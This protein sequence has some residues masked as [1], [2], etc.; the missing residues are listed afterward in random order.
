MISD[1]WWERN[2]TWAPYPL[3]AL[4]IGLFFTGR[5]AVMAYVELFRLLSGGATT[6]MAIAGW[7]LY[8]VPFTLLW[9][10]IL[11]SGRAKNCLAFLLLLV[12]ITLSVYPGGTNYWL[13]EAVSGPGGNAFVVGMRNGLLGGVVTSFTVPFV[14]ASE[15]LRDHF[16]VRTLGW[17]LAAPIGTFL[18]ATL[19]AAITLAAS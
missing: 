8:I 16:G 7:M 18:I 3:T 13:G 9:T 2:R 17:M 19:A 14:L 12:P 15:R 5:W 1:A 4:M 6:V 10:V 11:T